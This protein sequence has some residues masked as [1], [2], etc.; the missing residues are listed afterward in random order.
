[1][2]RSLPT[3]VMTVLLMALI[4]HLGRERSE[5]FP[6]VGAR[7]A[8]FVT[9]SD[10]V[11]TIARLTE[12]KDWATLAE[13]FDVSGS[14]LSKSDLASGNLFT[15]RLAHAG[16]RYNTLFTP[17][18]VTARYQSEKPLGNGQTQVVVR[19]R[20]DTAHASSAALGT[21]RLVFSPF[22]Y[23]IRPD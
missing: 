3:I 20:D 16:I 19:F 21:Y 17:F 1:V 14:A 18:P 15:G 5:A 9:P 6:A 7:A 11:A 8:Y 4:L 2:I 22:G 23:Q 10:S 12:Q 13:Y